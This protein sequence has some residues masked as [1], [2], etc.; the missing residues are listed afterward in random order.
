LNTFFQI[1]GHLFTVMLINA[2]AGLSL[3]WS[4]RAGLFN[5]STAGFM[6]IG[7]YTAAI[8]TLQVGTPWFLN[9]LVAAAA[10][11]T[12]GYLLAFPALRLKSHY[13]A[14]ATL[15]FG[16]IVQVL[17]I[18]LKGLTRG[19][20]GLVG[21]PATVHIWHAVL[22]LGFAIYLSHAIERSRIGRAWE[23]IRT[24]VNHYKMLAFVLSSAG[25]AVAGA[26]W[27][28]VN[29]VLV[30]TEFGFK[31]LTDVLI[32][33][34]MGGTSHWAG[35]VLGAAVV[36]SMPEWFRGLD[37]FRPFLIGTTLVVVVVYFRGGLVDLLRMLPR[38]L[39][40]ARSKREGASSEAHSVTALPPRPEAGGE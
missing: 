25:A 30:P 40:T 24:D 33:A 26:F 14:M 5:L 15:G 31:R 36:T 29:R 35:P 23:A 19:M 17:G 2:V 3:Y 22:L 1:Y 27:A 20:L 13:L 28:H 10:G 32:Y 7:A 11:L 39:Q 9:S 34:L 21:I 16:A 4:L 8:L 6:S 18:N 37:E 38:W 12:V